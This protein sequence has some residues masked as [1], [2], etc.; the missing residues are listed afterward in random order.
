MRLNAL[1]VTVAVVVL[2]VLSAGCGGGNGSSVAAGQPITFEKLAS[3]AS[4]SANAPTGRFG[5][6]LE[7]A[8]P[9]AEGRLGFTG[10][11][12]FDSAAQR[13]SMSIDMSSFAELFGGLV[14][15][16]GSGSGAPD[17]GNADAWK[18]DAV[19]DG[20]VLYMRF[21]AVAERLPGGK[22]WVR[23]DLSRASQ[24][25][26][27]DLAQLQQF[28]SNDPR[29]VLD[30]LRAVSGEIQTVGTEDV[31]GVAT[32]RYSAAI[33]L[34]RYENLVPPEQRAE[35][36]SLL[37]QL[38]EQ[39]GISTFPVDV[40]V[41]EYGLVRKLAMAF[42]ATQ[43]GTTQSANASMTFEL[44]DYGQEVEIELPPSDQVVDVTALG[45]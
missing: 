37:G 17:L 13:A 2:G 9:G 45:G 22:P 25:G 40:W 29:K 24:A 7:M 41:D 8:F 5:F 10:E 35:L 14:A 31:R 28:T 15:G 18:I 32:T 36:R 26:G 30:Y 21:P 4:T 33:D 43:P 38:V 12:A 44:Y 16:M 1:A 11:G 20:L 6:K 19:Q 39:S 42:S 34:R 3:V 23:I 27:F